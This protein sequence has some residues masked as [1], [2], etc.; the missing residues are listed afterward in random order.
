ML[1]EII[2]RRKRLAAP[3]LV[4]H[5]RLLAR[6]PASVGRKVGFAR[7]DMAAARLRTRKRA[8]LP[9]LRLA[10]VVR[11]AAVAVFRS[12]LSSRHDVD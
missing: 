9:L 2:L 1:F 3:L 12:P 8:L 10:I 6:V 5:E 7:S 4:A 11:I